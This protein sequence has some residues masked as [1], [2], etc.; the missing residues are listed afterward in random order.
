M[1]YAYVDIEN[2]FDNDKS[3]DLYFQ[4]IKDEIESPNFNLNNL[5]SNANFIDLLLSEIKRSDASNPE[6][7]RN[8]LRIL[9][10][11][12]AA[13]NEELKLSVERK[14][15]DAVLKLYYEK[16][17]LANIFLKPPHGIF[18]SGRAALTECLSL[19]YGNISYGTSR[20]NL[21]GTYL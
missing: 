14:N 2:V 9:D 21:F 4:T 11:Y 18:V 5:G 15:I 16:Q 19:K 1:P 3:L 20:K 12:H 8:L 7:V 6:K 10:A 13:M 17:K